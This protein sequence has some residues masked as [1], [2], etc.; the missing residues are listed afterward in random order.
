MKAKRILLSALIVGVFVFTN[1]SSAVGMG[2]ANQL[3]LASTDAIPSNHIEESVEKDI[4]ITLQEDPET[5]ELIVEPGILE[6]TIFLGDDDETGTITIH[7]PRNEVAEYAITILNRDFVPY[8][9]NTPEISSDHLIHDVSKDPSN[10]LAGFSSGIKNIENENQKFALASKQLENMNLQNCPSLY[11]VNRTGGVFFTPNACNPSD[12]EFLWNTN[13]LLKTTD[14]LFDDYQTLYLGSELYDDESNF[15]SY[16]L[17]ELDTITGELTHVKALEGIPH[18]SGVGAFSFTAAYGFFYVIALDNNH[19][20]KLYKMSKFGDISFIGPITGDHAT[21]L[22]IGL[23]YVPKE[24]MLYS[25]G[26]GPGDSTNIYSIN[27][28]TAESKL[29]W[30][31]DFQR[32]FVMSLDYD[33]ETETAYASHILRIT[34]TELREI[35]LKTGRSERLGYYPRGNFVSVAVKAYGGVGGG[36][37]PWI[38][39]DQSHGEIEAQSSLTTN[40]HFSARGIDQPG[41]YYAEIKM[42]TGVDYEFVRIP[43]KFN[44][45]RPYNWGTIKGTVYGL[46][47]CDVNPAEISNA[48]VQ[49]IKDEE[50]LAEFPT[51]ANG[52]FSYSLIEGVYDLKINAEDFVE[53]G[54]QEL[55]VGKSEDINLDITLRDC[56]SCLNFDP[57]YSSVG[58]IPLGPDLILNEK[59]KVVN[60]GACD[61]IVEIEE[62]NGAESRNYE[63]AI[64]DGTYENLIGMVDGGEIIW[65]NEF[66][67]DPSW[68]PFTLESVQ[69]SWGTLVRPEDRITIA[70]YKIGEGGPREPAQFLGKQDGKI[71]KIDSGFVDYVFREPITFMEATDI[72]IAV[73]NRD[74]VVGKRDYPAA[75]DMSTPELILE[76]SWIGYEFAPIADEPQVPPSGFWEIIE[77]ISADPFNRFW[78]N[79]L[80]RG[81]GSTHEGDIAW[82][83]VDPTAAVVPADGGELE[84]DLIFDPN[85]LETGSYHGRLMI[86]DWP[87]PRITYPVEMNILP[88]EALYLPLILRNFQ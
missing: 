78:G 36:G 4:E 64:D 80:I 33:E 1:F 43:V 6:R 25:I 53:E 10:L 67:I 2:V 45:V 40:V 17:Y 11:T 32:Q 16:N 14:I 21:V 13:L 61:A 29:E 19:E 48:T 82:L 31:C 87:Y 55:L 39:F 24:D 54:I 62:K 15:Q 20:A 7:N 88:F 50:V 34:T 77:N 58:I 51:D 63:L 57:D 70:V 49:I 84:L 44:V 65:A 23:L 18:T 46:E 41:T 59:L 76:K 83:T 42:Y 73:V 9:E 26:Q 81:K 3:S 52:S 47:R 75:L 35:N 60:S 5:G 74:G 79:W 38:Q 30:N 27:P 12:S 85:G 37:V 22:S 56:S 71:T 68:V 28:D 72:F 66:T 8:A 86:N 69:I